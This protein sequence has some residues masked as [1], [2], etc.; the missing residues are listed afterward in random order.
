MRTDFDVD[1]NIEEEEDYEGKGDRSVEEAEEDK[2]QSRVNRLLVEDR[3]ENTTTTAAGGVGPAA[4]A[5]DARKRIPGQRTSGRM[6]RGGAGSERRSRSPS[7]A[8]ALC[9]WWT[10][11]ASQSPH[12]EVRRAVRMYVCAC[13][14]VCVFT[15]MRACVGGC[16]A[17]RTRGLPRRGVG[18]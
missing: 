3:E 10:L 4:A 14:C 18:T 5:D 12:G 13:V 6:R 16:A 15:Y 8:P 9:L 11:Q 2:D 1:E 17:L 7:K